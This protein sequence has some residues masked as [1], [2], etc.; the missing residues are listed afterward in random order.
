MQVVVEGEKSKSVIVESGVPQDT[1]LGPLMFLCHI[2][3]LPDVARSQVSQMIIC[4]IAKSNQTNAMCY[5][6]KISQYWKI[7]F[8]DG[9]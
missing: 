5:S 8:L 6:K 1:V 2:H 9:E 7:G 3:D 4:Y